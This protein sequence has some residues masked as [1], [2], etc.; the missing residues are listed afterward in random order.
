MLH[1]LTHPAF[2]AVFAGAISENFTE[3][4]TREVFPAS[5]GSYDVES[6]QQIRDAMG[7]PLPSAKLDSP[8][9]SLRRAYFQGR[10]D[11]LGWHRTE[12][13]KTQTDIPS[14]TPEWDPAKA[15]SELAARNARALAAQSPHR[16][17]IGV[18]LFYKTSG[19]LLLGPRYAR[20][21]YRDEPAAHT[22]LYVEGQVVGTVT[23]ERR[24]GASVGLGLDVQNPGSYR[25]VAVRA[26]GTGALQG[27]FDPRIDLELVGKLGLRHWHTIRVGAEGI[28][29][30][31]VHGGGGPGAGAAVTIEFER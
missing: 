11:L 18:G 14:A 4:F 24:L 2:T 9:E 25:G 16:N 29:F 17:L 27:P 6:V 7:G 15:D 13:E 19:E 22:Q 8:E 30:V 5:Q 26:Q 20:V 1:Q 12:A 3:Y 23:G 10:L 31:P 28:V 21:L